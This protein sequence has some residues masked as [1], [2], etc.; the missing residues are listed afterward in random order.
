M[1]L[2]VFRGV[3]HDAL[4]RWLSA[5]LVTSGCAS[6][7]VPVDDSLT[8][9]AIDVVV[10]DDGVR[11]YPRG[12]LS[13]EISGDHQR[14]FPAIG[15]CVI[16][17]DAVGLTCESS[18]VS[19]CFE[20]ISVDGHAAQIRSDLDLIVPF[21]IGVDV[22][23]SSTLVLRG[24]GLDASVPVS[25]EARP[26]PVVETMFDAND[27]LTAS[28]TTEHQSDSTFVQMWAGLGGRS[29]RVDGSSITFD[30]PVPA[31]G[32]GVVRVQPLIAPVTYV[33]GATTIRVWSGNVGVV[34][35]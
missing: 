34:E 12:D 3:A 21:T 11:V 22:T 28:W 26:T 13:C 23:P 33:E 35:F 5:L 4:V 25:S 27:Y 7:G 29:C 1:S 19:T 31:L 8:V 30:V 32:F 2:V 20:E 14:V 9:S 6:E 24:C 15:E 18:P 17:S 10:A 16:L